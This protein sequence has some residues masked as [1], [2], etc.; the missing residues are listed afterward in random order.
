MTTTV[1]PQ[2]RV[3][4]MNEPQV[5]FI[6]N[7]DYLVNGERVTGNQLARCVD[8]M[9]EWNGKRYHDLLFEPVN[10]DKDSFTLENVTIGVSF[11]WKRKED[12]TFRGALH[13]IVENDKIT[14]INILSVEEYLLS[15]I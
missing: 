5:E 1:V 4:I 10:V 13:L 15:V 9:V 12:Q 11:H 8:G 3:G 2:V 7:N 14:T 6:L